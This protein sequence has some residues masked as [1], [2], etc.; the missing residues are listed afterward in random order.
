MSEVDPSMRRR[1]PRRVVAAATAVVALMGA[2]CSKGP[3]QPETTKPPAPSTTVNG[4][5]V[6]IPDPGEVFMPGWL[7]KNSGVLQGPS[8]E[9]ICQ[10]HPPIFEAGEGAD[11]DQSSTWKTAVRALIKK[12]VVIALLN[13][14]RKPGIAF[15]TKEGIT[16]VDEIIFNPEAKGDVLQVAVPLGEDQCLAVVGMDRDPDE[17]DFTEYLPAD[18]RNPVAMDQ[19]PPILKPIG[20]R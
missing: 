6:T 14:R 19:I 11:P 9:D 15:A 7:T 1:G 17:Y 16:G 2:S 5:P 4:R 18:L 8:K 10:Q 13:K 20:S 12:D 3:G